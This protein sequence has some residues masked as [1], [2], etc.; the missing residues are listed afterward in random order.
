ME[1]YI[2]RT[3]ILRALRLAKNY[4]IAKVVEEGGEYA[5]MPQTGKA[6]YDGMV[7]AFDACIKVVEKIE[8]DNSKT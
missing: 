8:A 7:A 4:A 1:E 6:C 2:S 3:S 5:K